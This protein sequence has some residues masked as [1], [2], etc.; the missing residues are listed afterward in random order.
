MHVVVTGNLSEGEKTHEITNGFVPTTTLTTPKSVVADG[1]N[2]VPAA[3]LQD[4]MNAASTAVGDVMKPDVVGR[5][6]MEPT[7][8]GHSF[9]PGFGSVPKFKGGGLVS[10]CRGRTRC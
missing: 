9:P 4:K 1:Y 7:V 8:D 5:E 10:R 3:E 2:T 6:V